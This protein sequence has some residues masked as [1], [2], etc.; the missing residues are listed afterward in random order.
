MR[1]VRAYREIPKQ[2]LFDMLCERLRAEGK[3]PVD[4]L[5]KNWTVL[6]KKR[7]KSK[8]GKEVK[9]PKRKA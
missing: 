9:C 5:T 2:T 7:Y 4:E 6:V 8:R 3:D 1:M